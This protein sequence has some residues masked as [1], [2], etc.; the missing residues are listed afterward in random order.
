[1]T[2]RATRW[3]ITWFPPTDS[4][5]REISEAEIKQYAQRQLP[6]GWS[7]AGQME[8]CSDTKR[9]HYQAML[10]TPQ[11]R[12]SA[13][14]SQ[15]DKAHV[16]AAK[17]VVALTNYVSKEDTR[18]AT[19]QSGNS[20]PTVFEYQTIVAQQWNE[21]EFQKVWKDAIEVA[22]KTNTVPDIDE[23][24]MR[25]IDSI[26]AADIESGRRGAEFIA[27]NPMWRSSWKRFWRSIIK[28]QCAP[29]PSPSESAIVATAAE[30]HA[31]DTVE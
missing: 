14:I 10:K 18:V 22:T 29:V 6:P 1:M 20:I 31:A 5:N 15:T 26:V 13:V 17:N 16:E 12:K 11:V 19:I 23:T 24:A 21:E 4:M 3:S 9:F 8:Q 25:Y 28:R 30:W 7:I 2:E 27:I